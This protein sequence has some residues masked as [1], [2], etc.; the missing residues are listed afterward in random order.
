MRYCIE[1]KLLGQ[2]TEHTAGGNASNPSYMHNPQ[3]KIT[4]PAS[5]PTGTKTEA[6][7]LLM[8]EAPKSLAV[9][10]SLMEGGKRVTT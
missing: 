1:K 3:W 10:L 9:H 4:I 8:L 5:S 7:L 2:W 6:G